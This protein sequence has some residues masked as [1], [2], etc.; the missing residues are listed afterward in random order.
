MKLY[1]QKEWKAYCEQQ[2]KLAGGRC[3]HCLRSRDEVVLQ[4]HH[5]HYVKGRLPWEYPYDECDVL[6]QGCHAKE[7]G[8]IMPSKDWELIGHDDLGARDGKCDRCG[9]E[10]RYTHMVFHPSWGTIIV[11]EKCCDNLT[12]ST[13]GTDSHAEFLNYLER[14][15]TFV[16]SNQWSVRDDGVR[17]IKRAGIRI[18]IAATDE[19]KFRVRLGGFQGK[20]DHDAFLDAQIWVFNYVESG[21][22]ATV[23]RGLQE[24]E[25]K[26]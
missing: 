22:A 25:K 13:V 3:A 8:I 20:V 18:E 15:K 19:G 24:K 7:H 1:R 10:L 21:E 16:G 11:G 26:R 6:C 4:V 17:S 2:I 5:R 23:L 12:E 14:R 9:Q